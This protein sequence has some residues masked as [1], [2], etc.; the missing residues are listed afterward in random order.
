MLFGF[1]FSLVAAGLLLAV[2]VVPQA[3]LDVPAAVVADLRADGDI[4]EA[5]AKAKADDDPV[6]RSTYLTEVAGPGAAIVAVPV[7]M[8][9]AALVSAR[10]PNRTRAFTIGAFA[11]ALFLVFIPPLG[12]YYLFSAAGVGIG[13]YQSRRADRE[14]AAAKG[15]DDAPD[16]DD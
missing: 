12:I 11:L 6:Y 15:P 10:R 7:L 2:P 5:T 8:A 3:V 1:L 14:A 4:P 13:A 16:D 9:G